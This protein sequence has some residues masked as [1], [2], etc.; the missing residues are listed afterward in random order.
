MIYT[1][2]AKGTEVPI[3][4]LNTMYRYA[5]CMNP[6]VLPVKRHFRIND[7]CA[8]FILEFTKQAGKYTAILKPT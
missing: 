3:S 2:R 5:A 8:I 4:S 6:E 7:N 1:K